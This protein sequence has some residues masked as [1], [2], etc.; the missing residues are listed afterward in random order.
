MEDANTFFENME[1]KDEGEERVLLIQEKEGQ[2]ISSFMK[3]ME[4]GGKE[5]VRVKQV[6]V[7]N[8]VEE[9]GEFSEASEEEVEGEEEEIGEGFVGG[10]YLQMEEEENE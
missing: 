6:S 4:G 8:Y 7:E 1:D 2:E 9:E 3:E 10:E 5:E